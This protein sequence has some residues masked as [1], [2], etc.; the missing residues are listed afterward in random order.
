MTRRISIAELAGHEGEVIGTS[1]WYA[2]TQERINAFA[3]ATGD[4]SKIHV[5]PE[6]AATTPIGR[7]IA[8][9]LFTLSLGP[10]FLVEVMEVH[11]YSWGLSY[12]YDR[13]RYIAPVPEG[14]RVRMRLTLQGVEAVDG[15]TRVR[16]RQLFELEGSERPAAVADSISMYFS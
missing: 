4:F 5:D 8:H 13:I 7:T 3:S 6:Q 14:S 15:G 10:M 16:F 2:V 9:G 11:G 1:E 12:G